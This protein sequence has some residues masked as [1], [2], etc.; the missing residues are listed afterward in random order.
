MTRVIKI[1]RM[2]IN[3]YNEYISKS[4]SVLLNIAFLAISN[5]AFF[6]MGAPTIKIYDVAIKGYYLVAYF[7]EQHAVKGNSDYV[8]KPVEARRL[9]FYLSRPFSGSMFMGRLIKIP[10][11][12]GE[13]LPGFVRLG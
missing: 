2:K 11:T 6:F 10:I 4:I 9:K 3:D 7:M 5:P 8:M 13:S 12:A 1:R